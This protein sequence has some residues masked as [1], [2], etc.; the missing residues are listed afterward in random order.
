MMP[1]MLLA[2]SCEACV[3]FRTFSC[4]KCRALHIQGVQN[5]GLKTCQASLA[6]ALKDVHAQVLRHI[7]IR[8][9]F[10]HSSL[11]IE[12]RDAKLTWIRKVAK[13]K[14]RLSG[15]SNPSNFLLRVCVCVCVCVEKVRMCVCVCVYVCVCVE[16]VRICVCGDSEHRLYML[17]KAM[18]DVFCVCILQGHVVC[19]SLRCVFH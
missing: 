7:H 11:N 8:Q 18:R 1:V 14:C 10:E 5:L 13:G 6:R 17:H 16:K 3:V 4:V 9:I 2:H 15:Q 12:Q 19:V